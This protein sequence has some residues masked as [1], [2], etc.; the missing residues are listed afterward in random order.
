MRKIIKE[1]IS[2][3]V[4]IMSKVHRRAEKIKESNEILSL[5]IPL[6]FYVYPDT[7]Q[8]NYKFF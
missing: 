6:F 8:G 2:P 4:G 1:V 5:T 7:E 3:R